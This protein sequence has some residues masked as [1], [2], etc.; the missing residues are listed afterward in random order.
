MS[1]N[2]IDTVTKVIV[3][4]QKC[5]RRKITP[6]TPLSDLGI[7][8]LRAITIIYELEEEFGVEIPNEVIETIHTVGD[9]VERLQELSEIKTD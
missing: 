5:D 3:R 1:Q 9:I 4:E 8:S 7:D 2:V 6:T